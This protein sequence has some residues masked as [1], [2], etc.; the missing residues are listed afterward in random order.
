MKRA[1]IYSRKSVFKGLD[2]K[3]NSLEAQED[4]AKSF[5]HSHSAEG[6]TYLRTYSDAGLS[7]SNTNRPALQEL[8]AAAKRKEFEMLVVF[9]LDRLAR[10]Q[11]D[12]L[13][14]LDELANNGVEV[15]SVSEPFDTSTYMG[16]AMRNLL[17]VFAE[18]ERE[19]IS[20]RTKA[21]MEA[22]KQQGYF[23]GGLVPF[24]YTREE[25]VLYIEPG[26]ARHVRWIFEQYLEH[27]SPTTI[28][29]QLNEK[30]VLRLSRLGKKDGKWENRNIHNV[31]RNPVYCGLIRSSDGETLYTGRHEAIISRELWE[32]VNRKID[33]AAAEAQEKIAGKRL[34]LIFPLNK[35]LRCGGCG[36]P[37]TT[38]YTTKDGKLHRYYVCKTR[39]RLGDNEKTGGCGCPNLNAEDVE[40]FVSQQLNDLGKNPNLLAAVINQLTK[41]NEESGVNVVPSGRVSDSLYDIRKL[42]DYADPV[43]MQNLFN[44]MFSEIR[45]NWKEN[46]LDFRYKVPELQPK[47]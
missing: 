39:K 6:W 7:G 1:V 38:M 23:I 26:E 9:K 13:N 10:N 29:R 22:S 42:L 28:A 16:R 4:M 15:A 40:Q 31:L 35:I 43:E 19:M 30:K 2:Q 8:L 12:F 44:A 33:A 25:N 24:G 32:K 46:M 34:N 11:R 21:K 41:E 3:Y 20:E 5:I 14:L 37:M 18:M 36:K 17:G 45:L 27:G 47:A